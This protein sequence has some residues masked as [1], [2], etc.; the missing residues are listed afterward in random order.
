MHNSNNPIARRNDLVVQEMADEVLVYD[1]QTNKAHCL[2]MSAA[3]VWSICD[4]NHSVSDIVRQ[5]GSNGEGTVTEDFVWLALDQ[6]SETG[7]LDNTLPPRFKG[8]SR[9]NVLKT[10]GL[11]SVVALPLISSLVA[12]RRAFA[13]V[14][15]GCINPGTCATLTGCPSLANCNPSGVCA[16]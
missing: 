16:P 13:S 2:N 4:G 11:A 14:S 6:L 10:I 12:P 9:R 5:I 8:Q 3:R 7:L 15:C 1:T